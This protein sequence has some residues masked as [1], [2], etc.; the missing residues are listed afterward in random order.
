MYQ[1]NIRDRKHKSARDKKSSREFLVPDEDQQYALV[2]AM[3]GNGRIKILCVDGVQRTGRIRGSMRNSR[4]KVI[5]EV[6]DI[7]LVS[8]RG[9]GND[10]IMDI[11][12]KFTHEEKSTLVLRKELPEGLL[13]ELTR[14]DIMGGS[15]ADNYVTYATDDAAIDLI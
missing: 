4:H 12:H 11:I 3:M 10:D 13:L 7:V 6:D 1:S 2:K 9:F 14:S 15:D 8:G 5:I